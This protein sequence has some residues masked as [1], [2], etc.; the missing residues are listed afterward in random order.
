MKGRD[1]VGNVRKVPLL[2][3]RRHGADVDAE[4][5]E[6]FGRVLKSGH[7]ILGPEVEAFESECAKYIG[8][9]HAVGVSSG[10]DALLLA[11][12][13]LGIGPGDEVVCPTYTFFATAGAVSRLGARPVFCDIHPTCYNCH[14]ESVAG[15]VTDKT[16]AIIP[17]HLFGQCADMVPIV[18]LGR[19]KGI[20]I[21]EDA[22]QAIGA[23]CESGRAG[24]M[25]TFGCFSFFPSKNLGALGDAGLLTTNDAALAKK[26]RVLR[27][28][29]S[30]PKYYHHVVGGNFRIDALQ[31]ALLRVKLPR[32]DG[33][34]KKRQKN[35]ALY[36]KLFLES[37]VAE[38]SVHERGCGARCTTGASA[39]GSKVL[40]PAA[41]Q[42]RHI[43]NQYVVRVP[44][45]GVRD[46]LRAFLAERGVGTE[47]YY[48]VP[49]HL[50]ACF[51]DL[52]GRPGDL[53]QAERAAK[54]TLALPIFP[55]ADEI[56]YVV[57]QVAAFFG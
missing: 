9:K 17:V 52:G 40:L 50:Q 28:H 18:E 23:A 27:A 8:A 44:G 51:A 57:E 12:M 55:E 2:D 16:K 1:G 15:K 20:A 43:Y 14:P 56:A 34:T 48:P 49:M 5:C 11:L 6:A 47:I 46:G 10:T 4:L 33:N 32:L 22:A 42:A 53:P 30:A 19:E 36:T 38:T 26:A 29:G 21:I 35:A 39:R 41:C 25:G 13:T 3:L 24:T 45:E 7:Y 54:E 31:A 37:A